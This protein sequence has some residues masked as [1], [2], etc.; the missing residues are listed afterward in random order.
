MRKYIAAA[1]AIAALAVT[2]AAAAADGATVVKDAGCVTNF[3]GTTCTVVKTATNTTI[4]PNG[5]ISYVTNGTVERR[6]TF[7]FGGSYTFTSALHM[8]GLRAQDEVREESDHY[9]SQWEYLSGTYH[10]I[11][12]ESYDLHWANDDAQPSNFELYCVPA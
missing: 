12:V 4:T 5:K 10:L 2:G 9:T 8:H 1:I 7:V 11:C 6:I 3:F